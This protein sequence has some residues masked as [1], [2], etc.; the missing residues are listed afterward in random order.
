MKRMTICRKQR[1]KRLSSA[2]RQFYLRKAGRLRFHVS[3]LLLIRLFQQTT[4]GS[5]NKCLVQDSPRPFA[6][7]GRDSLRRRPAN[8]IWPPAAGRTVSCVRKA[9]TSGRMNWQTLGVGNARPVV[10]KPR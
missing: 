1:R 2:G 9:V 8:N 5:M 6:S 7:F 10:I 4:T 3:H